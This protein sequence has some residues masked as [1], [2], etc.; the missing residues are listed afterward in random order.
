MY[1]IALNICLYL[2]RQMTY[3]WLANN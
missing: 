1:F 3:F 2:N